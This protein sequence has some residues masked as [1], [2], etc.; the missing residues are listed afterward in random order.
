METYKIWTR[1]EKA[2]D[3]HELKFYKVRPLKW[4]DEYI[5]PDPDEFIAHMEKFFNIPFRPLPRREY[6]NLCAIN[7]VSPL[8]DHE[9]ANSCAIGSSDLTLAYYHVIPQNRALAVQGKLHRMR[10]SGI[11]AEDINS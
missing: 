6:E 5:V 10:L 8:T 9:I 7:D 11:W 4:D 1:M 2:E 3:G